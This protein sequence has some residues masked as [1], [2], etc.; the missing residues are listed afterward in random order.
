MYRKFKMVSIQFDDGL[1][2]NYTKAFPYMAKLGAKGTIALTTNFINDNR[3][4]TMNWEQ[5]QE[6]R[7][8]GWD[9]QCHTKS[10]PRLTELTDEEIHEQYR[11]VNEEFLKRGWAPPKHAYIPH[12][13]I[14]SRVEAIVRQYREKIINLDSNVEI[15][16]DLDELGINYA[17]RRGDTQDDEKHEYIKQ[18]IDE[19]VDGKYDWVIIRGHDIR[20][21]PTEYQYCYYTRYFEDMID[22]IASKPDIKFV[23][24]EQGLRLQLAWKDMWIKGFEW[25]S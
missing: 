17:S 9:F 15:L 10:H 4:T 3:D 19:L 8:A 12:R 18:T 16:P 20:D 2:G 14:D 24:V 6:M 25:V 21:E 22:Y 23:T 1:L 13:A 5:V 7:N 11:T